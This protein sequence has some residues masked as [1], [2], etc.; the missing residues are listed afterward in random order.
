MYLSQIN[1]I[2]QKNMSVREFKKTGIQDNTA[3]EKKHQLS[4]D[5]IPLQSIKA[6]YLSFKGKSELEKNLTL[7]E[8][9]LNYVDDMKLI[10][11]TRWDEKDKKIS[12][13]KEIE[14]EYA[15]EK[16][17]YLDRERV[18][19]STIDE[20]IEF[21]AKKVPLLDV[22]NCAEHAILT[23]HY[24][25]EKR[26]IKNFALVAAISPKDPENFKKNRIEYGY[27]SDNHVFVVIGLDEAA[28]LEDPSTWG[29]NAVIV[30]PWGDVAGPV[31]ITINKIKKF[32]GSH[33]NIIFMNY[34]KFIDPAYGKNEETEYNWENYKRNLQN[35]DGELTDLLS[36]NYPFNDYSKSSYMEL[37]F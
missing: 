19:L 14:Y 23:A 11:T 37:N 1:F 6:H 9:A 3:I 22:G 31:N 10:S 36:S 15:I 34:A 35:E 25:N 8:D 18:K 13:E 27:N 16:R 24:L 28:D 30:D 32:T 20:F 2:K 21:T 26:N 5:K 33:D 17:R 12:E 4:L 7:A 29:K